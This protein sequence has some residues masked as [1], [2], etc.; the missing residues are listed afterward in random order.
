[1]IRL[2]SLLGEQYSGNYSSGKNPINTKDPNYV[3]YWMIKHA[4]TIAKQLGE[5]VNRLLGGGMNGFAWLLQSGRVMKLTP[6]KKEVAA[7]S[8]YR[9]KQA[10]PRLVAVYDVRPITGDR[11]QIDNPEFAAT[12]DPWFK[13]M[14][15]DRINQTEPWYVI[16][17]DHVTP[18]TYPESI[19]WRNV[20]RRYLDPRYPDD[21][22]LD[23][24]NHESDFTPVRGNLSTGWIDRVMQQRRSIISAFSRNRVHGDEAHGENM[25]W[26]QQ[27]KLVHFDWWMLGD[28]KA[29]TQPRYE[30]K[31]RRLNKAV[32]Y[33]ASGIDTAGDPN[34]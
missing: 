14:Q 22:V 7:A 18:F 23:R 26:N 25:G 13:R 4:P 15:A 10:V 1:M 24:L 9:T 32:R 8:R 30:T 29:E 12:T 6:D 33:D 20:Q 5:T 3:Q 16:I 19:I 11:A 27:G 17:M 31:P 28:P 2:K 21:Q 34:M